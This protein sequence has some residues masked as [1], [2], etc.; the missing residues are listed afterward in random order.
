MGIVSLH[1]FMWN[2]KIQLKYYLSYIAVFLWINHILSHIF[3][4]EDDWKEQVWEGKY[5]VQTHYFSQGY[6]L[7]HLKFR[8]QH[9]FLRATNPSTQRVIHPIS[10]E[11]KQIIQPLNH[12]PRIQPRSEVK[13]GEV[14]KQKK[15]YLPQQN[16]KIYHPLSHRTILKDRPL[17]HP[18]QCFI[19]LRLITLRI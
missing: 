1:S 16:S 15:H 11:R 9:T 19:S 4:P 5:Q 14:T 7:N 6:F 10:V 3:P 2:Q 8:G 13:S 12:R 18:K 17:T